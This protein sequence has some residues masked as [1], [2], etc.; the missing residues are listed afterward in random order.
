MNFIVLFVLLGING[1]AAL[2]ERVVDRQ[3]AAVQRQALAQYPYLTCRD[4]Y[5]HAFPDDSIR[6]RDL[7]I[8]IG[9]ANG[10][11]STK[12]ARVTRSEV[13]STVVDS[14]VTHLAGTPRDTLSIK[15]P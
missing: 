11:D 15:K 8:A 1:A 6:Q 14:L 12:L 4:L 9:C 5:G 7:M 13:E 10:R 3:D 2:R